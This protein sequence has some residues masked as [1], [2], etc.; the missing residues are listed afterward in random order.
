MIEDRYPAGRY[1]EETQ[2]L[3]RE[4]I[5][6]GYLPPYNAK[7]APSDDGWLGPATRAALQR[8]EQDLA[9][10]PAPPA[11]W[12]RTRRVW[13][14]ISA[15]SG[16]AGLFVP[17]L[18]EVDT[19]YLIELIWDNLDHVEQ[20]IT[21]LGALATVAGTVWGVIGA[22]KAKGPIDPTLLA[23]VGDH[24]LRLPARRVDPDRL[25]QPA[26]KLPSDPWPRS[27]YWS[28]NDRGPFGD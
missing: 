17:A 13:G 24:D 11:P 14:L 26:Q 21:A 19:T 6:G 3:Q 7:G 9:E 25:R 2:A 20:L 1:A 28:R 23:R 27:T 8:R 16:L 18:R 5:A 12:W 4:L 15:A 10:M 22:A